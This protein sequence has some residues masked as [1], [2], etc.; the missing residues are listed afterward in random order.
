MGATGNEI[1]DAF[2]PACTL[3]EL[4]A[5]GKMV[6]SGGRC[7]LLVI[8]DEGEVRALDNGV[9]RRD[10]P[11]KT[12]L[13]D[14]SQQ[15]VHDIVWAINTTPRKCLGFLTPAEAFLTQLWCCT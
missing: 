8:Y 4:K 1:R 3:G 13:A 7:P 10:L 6:V 12:D 15:D 2:I 9:L 14:Y 11:R 5:K